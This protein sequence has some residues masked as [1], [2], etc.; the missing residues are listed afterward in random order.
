[1]ATLA[2]GTLA[3]LLFANAGLYPWRR[4]WRARPLGTARRWLAF[5]IYGSVLGLVFVLLHTGLHWPGG[6]MGWLLWL[7]TA[8]TTATGVLGLWLQRT[9]PRRLARRLSVEAIYERIPELRQELVAEADVLMNGASDALARTYASKVRPSLVAPRVS[10]GW[11][12]ESTAEREQMLKPL[13][14][15]DA[16]LNDTERARLRD[17]ESIVHD[18]VDLDAQLSLQGVLRGWLAA[19]VPAAAALLALLLVHIAA[20]IWF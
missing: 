2:F 19:H 20:V 3:A 16:F 13:G 4:R 11:I 6:L 17:L 18:K 15:V 5:H 10:L 7:L 9:I 1:M 14:E 8:W 12:T